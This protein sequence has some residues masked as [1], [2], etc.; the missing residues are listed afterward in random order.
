ML[1]A[2]NQIFSSH[3]YNPHKLQ[4]LI[5][6]PSVLEMTCMYL[7]VCSFIM[8]LKSQ[9]I[10]MVVTCLENVRTQNDQNKKIWFRIIEPK[11]LPTGE[12]V[13]HCHRHQSF[14]MPT[15]Q[16][17]FMIL[18]KPHVTSSTWL[19]AIGALISSS[20]ANT[21]KMD[22]IEKEFMAYCQS[23]SFMDDNFYTL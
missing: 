23:F 1:N 2:Q 3:S 13:S 14:F 5:P 9:K 11:S 7:N 22:H 12:E 15:F 16:T 10:C 18:K 20:L 19:V 17:F 21:F 4:H 8:P 6:F